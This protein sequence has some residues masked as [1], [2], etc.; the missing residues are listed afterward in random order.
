MKG[1]G[2][3]GVDK[4]HSRAK[5]AIFLIRKKNHEI[6]GFLESLDEKHELSL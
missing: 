3:L 6:W 1:I 4:M 5:G 2:D